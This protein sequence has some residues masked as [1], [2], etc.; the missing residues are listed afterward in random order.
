MHG[1]VAEWVLDRYEARFY[2]M[3]F[4]NK[5]VFSPL[6]IPGADEF[7]RIVR[8]GS[9]LDPIDR[10]RSA[11]RTYSESDWNAQD[12]NSP[13]SPW[14]TTETMWVGFR[15]VRPL[16]TPTQEEIDRLRL[17]PDMPKAEARK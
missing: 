6:N 12:P 11:A 17:A 15:V 9:F 14:Y 8:G 3:P 4:D 10:L 1:N 16:R 13:P 5:A 2:A 7:P